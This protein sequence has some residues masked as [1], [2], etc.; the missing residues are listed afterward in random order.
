MLQSLQNVTNDLAKTPVHDS[1]NH[2]RPSLRIQVADGLVSLDRSLQSDVTGKPACGLQR[3]L[4][5]FVF[6]QIKL[7]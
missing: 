7:Y 5:C 4:N 2:N 6:N 3:N 1:W